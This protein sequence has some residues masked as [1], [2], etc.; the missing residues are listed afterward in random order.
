MNSKIKSTLQYLLLIAITTALLWLSL[1][2]LKVGD[3]EDKSEFIWNAWL[4]SDKGY[5]MLMV[6]VAMIS[7][8]LRAVR[9]KMLLEPT[10]HS[11]TLANSFL[12]LMIGY[13]VN[14][15][16]PRGGEVSRC[17]NLYKLEK[18]PVEVS[19][20][21]VVVERLVDLV[22]L[23]LLSGFVLLLNGKNSKRL[24]IH[25]TSPPQADRLFLFGFLLR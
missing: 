6:L 12:S 21:T 16:V 20:G 24:L 1:R 13:L 7:H 5:L 17:Y 2:G 8:L 3:G 14:L 25:L 23:V 22:C 18:T 9:W 4:R 11:V 19:F 15:A 10:G